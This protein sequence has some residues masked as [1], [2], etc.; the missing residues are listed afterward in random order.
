MHNSVTAFWLGI[1]AG[2]LCTISFI[3][4]VLRIAK[5]RH[6]RDLSLVTFIMFSC[7][8]FIWLLYGIVI[9]EWPVIIAN[10]VTLA[11]ALLILGM[12]IKY[13]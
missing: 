6:A 5:N 10:A 9:Q 13:G 2:T 12:K 7:G 4:Q 1:V 8:V 3:P 11:L